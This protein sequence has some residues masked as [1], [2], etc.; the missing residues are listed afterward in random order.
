MGG[1]RFRVGSV[2]VLFA[3]VAL[4]MAIFSTLTVVTAASDL[5]NAHRYGEYVQKLYDCQSLA[6]QWLAEADAYISGRGALPENTRQKNGQ[7]CTEISAEGML[8]E[9]RLNVG[10]GKYEIDCWK[11]T[12][13]WEPN[14]NWTLWEE[15][16]QLVG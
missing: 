6:E 9:I 12:T 2:A 1:K 14:D 4:C 3:A 16:M 13:Q 15:P 5:R 10:E 11:C 7:L 8:L